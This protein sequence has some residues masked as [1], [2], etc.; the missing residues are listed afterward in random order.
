[1][2]DGFF[3]HSPDNLN[4]L[5]YDLA[6]CTKLYMKIWAILYHNNIIYHKICYIL[7]VVEGNKSDEDLVHF[8]LYQEQKKKTKKTKMSANSSKMSKSKC[9]TCHNKVHFQLFYREIVKI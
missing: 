9:L 1:M 8:K 5:L 3:S 2:G 6:V 4:R 7:A